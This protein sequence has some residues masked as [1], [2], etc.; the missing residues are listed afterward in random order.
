MLMYTYICW[1]NTIS[2]SFRFSSSIIFHSSYIASGHS[3]TQTDPSSEWVGF[4]II[5]HKSTYNCYIA[6]RDICIMY[7][8]HLFFC[9]VYIEW[10]YLYSHTHRQFYPTRETNFSMMHYI[11]F[12]LSYCYERKR[13]FSFMEHKHIIQYITCYGCKSVAPRVFF[14][15]VKLDIFRAFCGKKNQEILVFGNHNT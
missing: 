5:D 8:V 6:N 10:L 2:F 9:L 14:S 15:E 11:C 3:A 4:Q 7:S 12:L 1:L 13:F